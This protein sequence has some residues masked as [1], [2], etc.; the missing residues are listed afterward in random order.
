MSTIH[1][2]SESEYVKITLG[3]PFSTEGWCEASVEIAVSCFHGRIEVWLDAFAIENFAIQLGAVYES[4]QGKASL[5]P[6]EGQFTLVLHA[7]T[8]GHIHVDG[9]AWSKATCG[10]KLEFELELDQSFL[11]KVLVQLQEAIS[12]DFR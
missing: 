4:L 3:L 9:T 5:L 12:K 7:Q 1:I 8:A 2:G 10:N 11:P 6:L